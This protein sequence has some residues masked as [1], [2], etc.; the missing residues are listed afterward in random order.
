[1]LLQ[2]NA[3]EKARVRN[4]R[5]TTVF[6]QYEIIEVVSKNEDGEPV[7]AGYR[8]L[9]RYVQTDKRAKLY[10]IEI[11]LKYDNNKLLD[12]IVSNNGINAV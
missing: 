12:H 2:L 7:F 5:L 1:M 6:G 11:H 8:C 3:R 10:P 9:P 4:N